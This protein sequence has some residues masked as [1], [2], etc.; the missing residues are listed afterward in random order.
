MLTLCHG[1]STMNAID[2]AAVVVGATMAAG[3]PFAGCYAGFG[4][5]VEVTS[6]CVEEGTNR[7]ACFEYNTIS[8]SCMLTPTIGGASF[9]AGTV[10]FYSVYARYLISLVVRLRLVELPDSFSMHRTLYFV[11]IFAECAG[12]LVTVLVPMITHAASVIHTTGFLVWMIG[13]FS[14]SVVM[15]ARA[16]FRVDDDAYDDTTRGIL[17]TRMIM[18]PILFV[19]CVCTGVWRESTGPFFRCTEYS[20]L[21]FLLTTGTLMMFLDTGSARAQHTWTS[22]RTR[23]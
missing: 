10:L 3:G 17:R 21:L 22:L 15:G 19:T 12:M 23:P 4:D 11:C 9:A 20:I 16:F 5:N 14:L 13:G 1:R 8:V 18:S 2:K 7:L 6:G